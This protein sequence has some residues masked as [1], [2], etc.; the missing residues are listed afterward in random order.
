M[1]NL[2]LRLSPR[3]V[4]FWQEFF[5]KTPFSKNASK[6]RSHRWEQQH[7]LEFCLGAARHPSVVP[8]AHG[9]TGI[10]V[11]WRRMGC[12]WCWLHRVCFARLEEEDDDSLAAVWGLATVASI[13]VACWANADPGQMPRR[14]R[15]SRGMGGRGAGVASASSNFILTLSNRCYFVLIK[16]G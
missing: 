6:F 1:Y 16:S 14:R 4:S 10:L 11:L 12:C 7:P 9:P 3:T 13:W 2:V 15:A 8:D 5:L